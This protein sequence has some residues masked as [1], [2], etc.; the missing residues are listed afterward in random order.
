MTR[1]TT[2]IR[3]P[4]ALYSRIKASVEAEEQ[5]TGERR[6]VQSLIAEILAKWLKDG[7]SQ[8]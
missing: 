5:A 4:L 6:S 7:D 1:T 2:S 3:I 8:K